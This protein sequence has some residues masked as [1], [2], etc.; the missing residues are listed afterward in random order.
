MNDSPYVLVYRSDP[1]A[2]DTPETALARSPAVLGPRFPPRAVERPTT[3]GIWDVGARVGLLPE[4]IQRLNDAQ[5]QFLFF[6]IA[7]IVPAGL[8]SQPARILAWSRE[9]MGRDRA[10]KIS[11]NVIAEDFFERARIVRESTRV[12]YLVGLTSSMVAFEEGLSAHWDYFATHEPREGRLILVSTYELARFAREAGR[13]FEMAVA[14]VLI[15]VFLVA[16]YR[17]VSGLDFHEDRGCLFDFNQERSTIVESFRRCAI[18][19]ACLGRI[20]EAD[21]RSVAD[22]VLE[23]EKYPRHESRR[24]GGGTMGSRVALLIPG[25]MG[26]ELCLGERV[27]WPGPVESLFRPYRMMAELM[28]DQLV[29]T[30][31]IRRYTVFSRQYETLIKDLGACGFREDDEPPTLYVCPYDWRRGNEVSA[32]TLAERLDT[33]LVQHPEIAEITIIAHS[34]GGLIARY[35]LESGEYADRPAIRLVRRL[36][37]LGT[38]HRGAPLTL[39][40]L[41]GE[42][43]SLWLSGEQIR[44][45]ASDPRYPAAYQLLPIR[46]EP[47]AWDAAAEAEFSSLDIYDEEL[48]QE[49]GLELANLQAAV[50]FQQKLGVHLKPK[51]VRYF[52]F[53]GTR[54]TTATTARLLRSPGRIRVEKWELDHGGDGTVPFWSS[55]LPGVQCLA[56]GGEHSVLY[57]DG[58]LRPTLAALL[59]RE[60]V[61]AAEPGRV[62][63][64]LRERVASQGDRVHV[65]L[66]FGAG[67]DRLEGEL[68]IEFVEVGAETLAFHPVPGGSMVYPIVYR[69]LAAETIGVTFDA[70]VTPGEYRVA[71]V[72]RGEASPIGSDELIVQASP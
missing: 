7:A 67:V 40:R 48:S 58:L 49:L 23:L 53:C 1:D 31:V 70:P 42:E 52:C 37:T 5:N 19:P 25:I 16:R 38:P 4:V 56:V 41:R 17:R 65:A 30:D 21:R 57:K 26:S 59:G 24:A 32:Q 11:K 39:P 36:I 14:S 9:R 8:I 29:A 3:L 66:T 54:Q 43:G 68:R 50:A 55:S 69:G 51:D 45:L 15:S 44:R 20:P 61:L 47:F 28:S 22:L 2:C 13:R 71:Y 34:M 64:A 18:E 72:P 35:Y 46:G 33:A 6:E 62:E 63:V 10:E 12:D 27:I 60:G